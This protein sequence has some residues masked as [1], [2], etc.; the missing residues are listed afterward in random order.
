[1]TPTVKRSVMIA[2]MRSDKPLM[3]AP[4][5]TSYNYGALISNKKLK[6]PAF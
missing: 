3:C 6:S 5:I 4:L 2:S 1:M